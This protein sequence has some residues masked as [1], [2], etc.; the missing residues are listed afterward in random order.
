MN[1]NNEDLKKIYNL[2]IYLLKDNVDTFEK[3]LKN[4]RTK[5]CV[6]KDKFNIDGVI[7]IGDPK[8]KVA[9]WQGL[10]QE[11]TDEVIPALEGVSNRAI[12]L[13]KVNNRVF[14]LPFGYG[15][16][17]LKDGVIDRDI[18]MKTALN[19]IDPDSLR[20]LDRAN[21]DKLNIIT[22]TQSSSKAKQEN[23]SVDPI[24][25][26]LKGVTG[27]VATGMGTLGFNIT[28]ND[29]LYLNPKITFED[30]G[31]I[32]EII[33]KA[34]SGKKYQDNFEW[35]DNLKQEKDP[36]IIKLLQAELLIDLQ[37]KNTIRVALS[38]YM[39]IP[40]EKL[41][42]VAYTPKGELQQDFNIESFYRL[43]KKEI[44]DSWDQFLTFSNI[45]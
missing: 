37:V 1:P 40:W 44:K 7:Y 16:H 45:F 14:A 2:S 24:K 32:I 11:A 36:E 34:T 8:S 9:T 18:A 31:S 41:E 29:G 39:I 15:K 12:L 38:P 23:F 6:I 43:N 13:A 28:G 22:R 33:Q 17:L 21:L 27:G 26:L 19:I 42:G 30:I 10:L 20:S 4:V 3:A 25:D 5:R 35:I